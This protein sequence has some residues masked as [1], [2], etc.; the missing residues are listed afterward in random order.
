MKLKKGWKRFWTL[1]RHHADGFTLVELIVVIAILA[2]LAGVGSVGYSGYIKSANK[3]NDKVLVG[4]IMRAIETGTYSTM[5]VPSES[6]QISATSYPVGFVVLSTNGTNLLTSGTTITKVEGECVFE[7]IENVLVETTSTKESGCYSN[8]SDVITSVSAGKIRY[9]ATHSPT[10]DVVSATGEYIS[11]YTDNGE[12]K[13]LGFLKWCEGHTWTAVKTPYP[14]N[15]KKVSNQSALYAEKSGGLCELAYA[16]QNGIY[17]GE[18]KV[19]GGTDTDGNQIPVDTTHPLYTAIQAA[20]GD[21]SSLKLSYDGWTADE[22]IDFATF[23]S[24]ASGVMSNVETLSG[25]LVW[26]SSFYDDFVEGDYDD[27]NEVLGAVA[28]KITTEHSTVDSWLDEWNDKNSTFHW[29]TESFGLS[30]REFYCAARVGY[31]TGFAT[32]LAA[33][34]IPN[35]YCELIENY[36]DGL[37]LPKLVC[38]NTFTD[39]ASGLKD[40]FEKHEDPDAENSVFKQI[41]SLYNDYKGSTA[42]TENGR[43]FYDTLITIKDTEE[44]AKDEHNGFNGDVFDYYLAYTDEISALYSEAQKN[45]K[46]GSIVII[47]SVKDGNLDFQVSPSAA[48]PRN[49]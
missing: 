17:T 47:V 32:Y 40:K 36:A 41:Q 8:E 4:N 15:S 18:N 1:N 43:V 33:N 27:K 37:G 9:C 11:D 31:N 13:S 28:N 6:L 26:A 3:N 21:L 48:N 45:V 23:Y 22:G 44:F 19:N 39:D 5:F 38:A 49:D 30:G 42:C 12:N 46:D 7:E 29:D 2:I 10:P 16:N 35:T 24:G 34:N 14:A 25:T 20:Y